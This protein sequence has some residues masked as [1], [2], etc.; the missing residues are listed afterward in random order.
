MTTLEIVQEALTYTTD[1]STSS[2]HRIIMPS[3]IGLPGGLYSTFKCRLQAECDN[4]R[5]ISPSLR[6]SCKNILELCR[7]TGEEKIRSPVRR[8]NNYLDIVRVN[9]KSATRDSSE[10]PQDGHKTTN[11]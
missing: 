1:N 9:H 11:R 8:L 2:Q 4:P 10:V 7:V 6:E 5:T 3:Q